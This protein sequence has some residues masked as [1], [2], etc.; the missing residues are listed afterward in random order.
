MFFSYFQN[1]QNRPGFVED[2]T[3]NILVFFR[4]TVYSF[5]PETVK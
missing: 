3:T 1:Y 4:F 5:M 2:M